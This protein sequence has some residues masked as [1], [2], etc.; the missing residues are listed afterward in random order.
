MRYH[1]KHV[2]HHYVTASQQYLKTCS[3]SLFLSA[4]L[5]FSPVTASD[6]FRQC[7]LK[8]HLNLN[9]S[10]TKVKFDFFFFV[11]N[12]FLFLQLF[13]FVKLL[14]CSQTY[15]CSVRTQSMILID[16]ISARSSMEKQG[17]W[18]IAGTTFS[19]RDT[20]RE[21]WSSVFL[22]HWLFQ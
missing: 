20:F 14:P 9:K 12:I 4:L 1:R 22:S 19:Q 7:H 21:S 16:I 17:S 15:A 2:L 5:H 11:W 8:M 13:Y 3:L 6:P 18:F 10:H